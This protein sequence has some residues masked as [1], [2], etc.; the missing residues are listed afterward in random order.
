M[1]DALERSSRHLQK[2]MFM[3]LIDKLQRK[4][5][6]YAIPN[7]T[8]YIIILYAAGYILE[9]F[10]PSFLSY[11][12]LEPALILKGQVWR[13]VTW[14]L[15]PPGSLDI[16]TLIMLAVYYS[17]GTTLE[18]TW[19]TFRY[20]LY[21]FTGV[22]STLIG[23]FIVCAIFA[24]QGVQVMMG[25]TFNTY[26]V[27]LSIFLAFAVSYPNMQMLLYFI[28]PIK[29]KWLALLD[30]IYILY[31]FIRSDW[32]N[33][34]VI[35]ASLFNFL[36]FFLGGLQ[37]WRVSPSEIRRKQRFKKQVNMGSHSH[38]GKKNQ[39]TKHKCAI[40]GRTE[41]DGD[42]LEFRFCSKCDGNYEYCQDHLFT[43]EHVHKK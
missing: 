38:T 29:I 28:I 16:F 40:C 13:L 4:F 23:A 6:R 34:V 36:L 42:D 24:A 25:T 12:T 1:K 15:I 26:Y 30:G 22:L 9:L 11:L 20:N 7:L 8:M 19:G 14:L 21:I 39:V 41:L 37:Y 35:I 32:V 10:Q 17:L 2:G 3:K 43:H 27:S 31:A 5:G 18:R 33:R